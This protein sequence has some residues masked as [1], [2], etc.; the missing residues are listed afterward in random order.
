MDLEFLLN[1]FIVIPFIGM[2]LSSIY[3]M[4][5]KNAKLIIFEQIGSVC[6]FLL[7]LIIILFIFFDF[8]K[9]QILYSTNNDIVRI[10]YLSLFLLILVQIIFL[11]VSIYSLSYIV[12]EKRPVFLLFV[13][14]LNL[15]IN[16]TLLASNLF[17]LFVSWE[18]MVISGYVLVSFNKT[19]DSLEAG[20]KYLVISSIGSLFML[21]GIGL[22]SGFVED[23]NFTTIMSS[24]IDSNPLTIISFVFIIIG[25]ITTGGAFIFNQWLPDAHPEAP[26]PI[27]ALLSGI[28]VNIGIY[29]VFIT[30]TLFEP[31]N[32]FLSTNY[33]IIII[34]IG[35]MTSIEGSIM[36][37]VQFRKEII[38][39]K[40]ILAYS[41]ISHMGLLI[42][43]TPLGTTLSF[44][45][46]IYHI[47]SHSFSKSLLF[48][49][50]GYLQLQYK[51][52]DLNL[53]AG[54]G[55]KDKLLGVFIMIG[56]LSLGGF[57][58]TTGFVSEFLI[59]YAIYSVGISSQFYLNVIVLVFVI[60]SSI[61]AFGGY[62][63]I[64]KYLILNQKSNVI[65]SSK[66]HVS[67]NYL[68]TFVM[69][70]LIILIIVFGVFPN[71]ILDLM[72]SKIP[73]FIK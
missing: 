62:V 15:G 72:N 40:R 10:N 13:F 19:I 11:L 36:V 50:A 39:I 45:A 18:L 63:W 37:F 46:M 58:G 35:L 59:F 14:S 53:L 44:L 29:G 20:I 61:I 38:D 66:V 47:F 28:V 68:I 48:L 27:S 60:M 41:T 12:K 30:F 4:F 67:K 23:L 33:E 57:P 24:N 25:F 71:V 49:I 26:A 42:I 70:V 65:L 17:V 73:Y 43:L 7:N 54:V 16:L 9:G 3:T 69:I 52:R 21:M 34:L 5:I 64:I 2:M 8:R 22:L 56:L 1:L 51:T 31:S 6:L 32:N 55:R